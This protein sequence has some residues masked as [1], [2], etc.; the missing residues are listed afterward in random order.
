VL[1][2]CSSASHP[3]AASPPTTVTSTTPAPTTTVP[4]TT[5][6]APQPAS[7]SACTGD[8]GPQGFQCATLQVPLNYAQPQLG[9]IGIA[10]DR[11]PAS[12]PGPRLGSLLINPGGPGASGVDFLA[13]AARLVSPSVRDRFDLIGFDPRGVARSAPVRCLDPPAMT[14][15]LD[16][17]PA[18]VT[19]AGF[20]SLVSA[21]RSFTQACESRSGRI[22]PYVSTANAAR[23]M[24][25]IRGSVGDATLSYLG[26]SYGSFLGATYAELFPRR[27]RAVVLDGAIDPSLGAIDGN[28]DQSV[29]FDHELTDFFSWCAATATC[30][31]RP[32]TEL[33]AAFNSLHDRLRSH[34]LSVQGRTVGPSEFF[35]GVAQPL[36]SRA[37]WPSLADALN[38]ASRGDG[39]LLL[40]FFDE[41]VQ[42]NPD[43]SYTNS[44]EANNAI[45]C[46]DEPWPTDV[47]VIEHDAATAARAAPEFGV[48]NLYGG[49]ACALWPVPATG[50]PHA[51]RA[52]GSPPILV[53]GS[54]GDPAT[55]YAQAQALAKELEHGVLIT[56]IGEG[57]T[58][59][60][61]SA[62]VRTVVDSYLTDLTVPPADPQC[63]SP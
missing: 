63:S 9:T 25:Q 45:S 39:T 23:D 3:R 28:I 54:T 40:E 48:A 41:Y 30:S 57:H 53:V 37:S 50:R 11:R 52:A 6:V 44:I 42:R 12:G 5:T 7:W 27:V 13:S 60:P 4:P 17:D 59:Y 10:L 1:A 61:S 19:N 21:D 14:Q 34:S 55:P 35:Y 46:L 38:E 47:T 20:Q 36:Y 18:P 29:G 16:V 56:R 62:C 58:G 8:A 26:F 22:L 51:I 32:G 49:V 15:F 31:W 43:G 33:R 24:D 2:G